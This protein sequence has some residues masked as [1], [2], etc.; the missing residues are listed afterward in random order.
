LPFAVYS[1]QH[2]QFWTLKIDVSYAMRLCRYG[3]FTLLLS[4]FRYYF[5]D[6]FTRFLPA[7]RYFQRYIR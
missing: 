4:A 6:I 1:D 5:A 3:G 2:Q 7:T